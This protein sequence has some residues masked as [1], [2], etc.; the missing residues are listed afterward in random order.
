MRLRNKCLKRTRKI[1]EEAY[2][3]RVREAGKAAKK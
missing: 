2:K 3:L 1:K